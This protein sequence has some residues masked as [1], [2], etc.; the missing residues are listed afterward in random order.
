MR[1]VL[2]IHHDGNAFNNP[3]LKALIDLLLEKGYRCSIRHAATGA[4]AP[5]APE[6][7]SLPYGWLLGKIRKWAYDRLRASSL[8]AAIVAIERRL[9]YA[10]PVLTIA[11][12]RWGLIEAAE[13]KRQL[14]VPFVFVSFEILFAAET[15]VAFKRMERAAGQACAFW[16]AQ[17]E[18]RAAALAAENALDPERAFILPLASEGRGLVS[19]ARLR[20]RLGIPADRKVAIMIGSLAAW[21]MAAEVIRSVDAWPADWILVVHERYGNTQAELRRMGIDVATLSDRIRFSAHAPSLV[22]DMGSVLS[23]VSAGIA[24]Y[25]PTYDSP[26]TGRNL[27]LIGRAA[28][29]IATY[30]R[31]GVPV[32]TNESGAY[33]RDVRTHGF[34]AVARHP[35]ELPAAL[36]SIGESSSAAAVDFFERHLDFSL[37]RRD[38]WSRLDAT[39]R[40]LARA[41]GGMHA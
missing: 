12:D 37:R 17:D 5:E 25:R 26:Y 36:A 8:V 27:E 11:V 23:G 6:V 7:V 22:D 38:L 19:P 9:L 3:S 29:K 13:L 28:G 1:H 39:I 40:P 31:Y 18:E 32:V 15:S 16:I 34:G 20:D 10:K 14:G 30:L 35:D 33:A 24:F 21:T 4:P 2:L 41:R